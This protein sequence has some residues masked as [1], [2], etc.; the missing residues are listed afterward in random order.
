VKYEDKQTKLEGI[1]VLYDLKNKFFETSDKVE[2]VQLPPNNDWKTFLHE[3]VLNIDIICNSKTENTLQKI[4]FPTIFIRPV[5]TNRLSFLNS[6]LSVVRQYNS[7]FIFWKIAR[8]SNDNTVPIISVSDEEICKN[9]SKNWFLNEVLSLSTGG[10]LLRY[11]RIFF[12]VEDVPS[13]MEELRSRISFNYGNNNFLPKTAALYNFDGQ[14]FYLHR[15]TAKITK[16]DVNNVIESEIEFLS[17]QSEPSVFAMPLIVKGTFNSWYEE[18]DFWKIDQL[19]APNIEIKRESFIY[20]F[21]RLQFPGNRGIYV[22]PKKGD[23]VLVTI[24]HGGL[25]IADLITQRLPIAESD[26]VTLL[27]DSLRF[28]SDK[29]EMKLKDMLSIKGETIINGNVKIEG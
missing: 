28:Q 25:P 10:T 29:T 13:V 26:T 22:P 18:T 15:L 7:S 3:K 23:K 14:K 2:I 12:K 16:K 4:A 20:V 21:P 11:K 1:L 5:N 27:G 17:H 8:S 9:F 6:I 19:E 24:P